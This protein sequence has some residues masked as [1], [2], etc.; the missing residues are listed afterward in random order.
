VLMSRLFEPQEGQRVY[1]YCSGESFRAILE[2]GKLRFSDINMLNDASEQRWGYAIFEEAATRLIKRAGI[3]ETVPKMTIEFFDAVD[4]VLSK[5]QQI[6]HPFVSCLSLDGNSLDQW[7]KYADDGQGYA[8][9][10]LASD[11]KHLPLSLV[12]VSYDYQEQVREMMAALLA[13]H[14]RSPNIEVPLKGESYTD[15]VLISTYMAALKHSSFS[16]EREV[17]CLRAIALE[18][19]G[20]NYKF[21][22]QGG[23][24]GNDGTFVPGE[25]VSFATRDG[26]LTAYVDLPFTTPS[27]RCPIVE[28]AL[29]PKNPSHI[30]NVFL[31][32]GALGH[33]QVTV[34]PSD[35]PY[36]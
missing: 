2:S 23:H 20:D 33:S 28:V 9:G 8:I 19:A 7:R 26:A 31:F 25:K 5:G 34:R 4:E 15:A 29:G 16:T 3:P 35:L 36:R 32:L 17:R 27:G 10:F 13:L 14:S 12:K 11:L 22:D 6:A 24:A 21:S 1:H 18:R 30:G